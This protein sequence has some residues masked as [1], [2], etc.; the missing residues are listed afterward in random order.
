MPGLAFKAVVIG[1]GYATGRELATFFTPSGARGG[2]LGMLTALLIW[3]LV[4]VLTYLFAFKTRSFDYRTFFKQLLGPF[5]PLFE[6]AYFLSVTVILAVYAAA[7]GSIGQALFGAQPLQGALLL[8]ICIALIATYGNTAVERLFKYASFFLYATYVL[9]V[10]L[11]L[12]K[13]GGRIGPAFTDASVGHAWFIGGVT[14][15]GYNIFGAVIILATLRH[16]ASPRDAII[17]G[18]WSGPLA[19]IPAMS[20]FICMVAF[21]PD[22][23]NETLPSDYMLGRLGIPAF[24]WVFQAMIFVALLESGTGGVHA[25]NERIAHALG[26]GLLGRR[27]RLAITALVLG[28]S[29]FIAARF[30]LV[31]LIAS[32]YRWIAYAI[33][34]I[35]VLPLLTLGAWRIVR[36]DLHASRLAMVRTEAPE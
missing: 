29:V 3:S 2:L 18:I 20:F 25:I 16:L 30:G 28:G 13:F 11:M 24:R 1:G 15:A 33:L 9:F 6:I 23:Q 32:G 7:A 19:M 5:W 21:L 17:A 8:M 10:I 27:A 31:A 36:G 35:Y 12:A 4:C 22:I 34:L 14:Y 26:A